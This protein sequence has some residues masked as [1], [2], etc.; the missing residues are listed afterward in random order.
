MLVS[1]PVM[2]TAALVFDRTVS[3]EFSVGVD[4][5]GTNLRVA[6]YSPKDGILESISQAT[7]LKDGRD[8]VVADMCAGV[9]DMIARHSKTKKLKG[10]GM[11]SPGPIELPGGLLHDLPNLP[12][13][14]GLELRATLEKNLSTA[15]II[16][17]DA[18]AAALAECFLGRGK[19]LGIDSLC[20]M[21]LGTGVGGGII[22]QGNI[23][24]GMNGFAGEIGHLNIWT[25]G[26]RC[27]CGGH[28]CTEPYAS[29]T[30]VRRAAKDLIASG[31]APGL[32]ALAA[33]NPDFTPRDVGL[34]AEAGDADAIRIFENLGQALGIALSAIVNTLNLPL[35][36]LGGGLLNAWDLFA[37][38]LFKELRSRSYIYRLTEPSDEDR[39]THREGKTYVE[40][41]ELGV[42]AGILGACLL[43]FTT[44]PE[45][46]K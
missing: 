39:R 23:L 35:Y 21:T 19:T 8:A 6:A 2:R 13:W 12:G 16:E 22:L 30:S 44:W 1:R 29:A 9:R 46:R 40:K 11:G 7:R 14:G 31:S 45:A 3:D 37:P 5:G 20:M 28:G 27:G 43:P 38:T 4:F 34:L 17:N 36:L 24:D 25:D 32:A 15:V 18:N 41:A 26:L 33:K 42:E 10:V